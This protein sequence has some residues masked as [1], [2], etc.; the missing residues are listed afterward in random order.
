MPRVLMV[1]DAGLFRMLE[2]SFLRRIGCDIVRAADENDLLARAR[3]GIVP[4]LILLDADHPGIDGPAC[5][6]T[7]RSIEELRD[8]PVLVVSEAAAVRP[9]R[10]A[11]ATAAFARP[12]QAGALELALGSVGKLGCRAGR[13]RA[14]R[15][16]AR[17]ITPMGMRRAR[18]K[19]ISAS[20]LFLVL[21]DPLPLDADVNVSMALP[22]AEGRRKIRLRG[23]VVRRVENDPESH[24]MP[25][26]G[27]RFVEID[28]AAASIIDTFLAQDSA[29]SVEAE[30][31]AGP[32]K[33]GLQGEREHS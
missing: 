33:A 25:G 15:V 12:L 26:V 17:I 5:V 3:G 20:G 19:D 22:T 18:V 16:P 29:G 7:L 9:C 31:T 27:V 28:P 24:L 8:T 1:D 6:R 32:R 11:G 4:D 13:R 21:P 10:E 2:A 14:L 23:V 30:A